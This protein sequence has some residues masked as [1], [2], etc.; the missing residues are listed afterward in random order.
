MAG[1][2]T[3]KKTQSI[4]D[5]KNEINLFSLEVVDIEILCVCKI[6]DTCLDNESEPITHLKEQ[7]GKSLFVDRKFYKWTNCK[8]RDCGICMVCT[9]LR[10]EYRIR[11]VCSRAGDRLYLETPGQCWTRLLQ[12]YCYNDWK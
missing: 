1:N 3:S 12:V 4:S 9:I 5:D 2:E 7:L 8:G 11:R 6:C 10:V